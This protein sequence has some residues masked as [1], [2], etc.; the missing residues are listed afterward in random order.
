VVFLGSPEWALH[1]YGHNLLDD[2]TPDAA[3]GY[4]Y[5][6]FNASNGWY[7]SEGRVLGVSLNWTM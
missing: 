1:I 4:Y 2:R 6:G 3:Y 7:P 5:Q